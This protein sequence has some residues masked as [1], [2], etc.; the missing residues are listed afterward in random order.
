MKVEIR[1]ADVVQRQ[2]ALLEQHAPTTIRDAQARLALAVRTALVAEVAGALHWSSPATQ[3]FISNGF[4]IRYRTTGGGYVA[5]VVALPTSAALIARHTAPHTNVPGQ[6]ADLEMRGMLAIP[7]PGV[8]PR[9]RDGRVPPRLLPAELLK[10]DARG[11][12][13]GFVNAAGTAIM[14]RARGGEP[15]PAYALRPRTAQPKRID[16]DAAAA[17]TIAREAAP[18]YAAAIAKAERAAGLR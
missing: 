16:L 4:Q 12:T 3:R 8:I 10:R 2:L 5:E 9:S 15:V 1:G 13:L 14:Y 7:V 17:R 18:A 6:R 11:R